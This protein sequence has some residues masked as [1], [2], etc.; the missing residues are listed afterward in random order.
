LKDVP[1]CVAETSLLISIRLKQSA[2]REIQDSQEEYFTVSCA[3]HFLETPFDF[4]QKRVAARIFGGIDA[5]SKFVLT[6]RD[7]F[8]TMSADAYY[9]KIK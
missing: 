2:H 6:F 3:V 4:P 8:R 1:L 9:P 7:T 5:D